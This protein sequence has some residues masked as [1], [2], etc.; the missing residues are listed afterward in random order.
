MQQVI[1]V[2][3]EEVLLTLVESK[4][5]SRTETY[6]VRLW[7]YLVSARPF[8]LGSLESDLSDEQSY[9]GIR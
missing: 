6:A 1:T 2:S 5:A 9:K 3:S 4:L 7:Y 8:N